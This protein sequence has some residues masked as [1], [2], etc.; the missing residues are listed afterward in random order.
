MVEVPRQQPAVRVLQ[1]LLDSS[2]VVAQQIVAEEPQR[3]AVP[4]DAVREGERAGIDGDMQRALVR[5]QLVDNERRHAGSDLVAVTE[6][7]DVELAAKTL[8]RLLGRAYRDIECLRELARVAMVETG[9]EHD[10]LG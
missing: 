10:L 4:V 3:A 6:E 5:G 9:R 8:E 2:G 7:L 1:A